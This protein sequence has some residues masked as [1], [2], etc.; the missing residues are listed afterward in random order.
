MN[1]LNYFFPYQSKQDY[2][3]DQLTRAFLVVLKHLPFVANVFYDMCKQKFDESNNLM[4]QKLPHLSTLVSEEW[5]FNTQKSNPSIDTKQLLSVLITDQ[6]LQSTSNRVTRSERLARYDGV[7][8]IGSDLTMIIENKPS[9]FNVWFDQL[10]P[11]KENLS[12]ETEVL[13]THVLIQWKDII[14]MLTGL[15]KKGTIQKILIDDFLSYIDTC[16]PTLNPFDRFS[17]CKNNPTLLERRIKNILEQI[18]S[19]K[20]LVQYHRGWAYKIELGLPQIRMVGLALGVKENNWW[21][22]LSMI[23]GNTVNQSRALYRAL[24]DLNAFDLG[25]MFPRADFHCAFMTK[26]LIWFKT[27]DTNKY[28]KYWKQ[29]PDEIKQYDADV[30]DVYLYKLNEE[31]IIIYNQSEE[32]KYNDVIYGTT[33][34]M[35]PGLGLI[36]ELESKDAIEL[37]DKGELEQMIA[38]RVHLALDI[39]GTS[40]RLIKTFV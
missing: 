15:I 26:N 13:Q 27:P 14:V 23:A 7:I 11:S 16:Y 32:K 5:D 9:S 1:H 31:D 28:I 21:L 4:S 17:L 6:S 37:D 25:G 2:H 29:H 36:W 33:V 35:C 3:E 39:F 34:N 12:A 30:I 24:K 18:V 40:T 10:S 22:E 20:T 8:T 19:D 38:D